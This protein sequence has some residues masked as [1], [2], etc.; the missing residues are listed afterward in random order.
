VNTVIEVSVCIGSACHLK[1]SYNLINIFQQ[2]IEEYALHDQIEVSAA[3]CMKHC[4]QDGVSVSID[5]AY[6][7][8]SPETAREFFL[9]N[10]LAKTKS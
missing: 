4:R 9:T 3:F 7:S 5:G 6:Y 2:L 1:G 8:V 10:V